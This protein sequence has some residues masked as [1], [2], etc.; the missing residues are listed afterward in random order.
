[1]H[2]DGYISIIHNVFMLSDK[3]PMIALMQLFLNG[4]NAI[5][6]FEV[7]YPRASA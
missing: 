1:M 6:M 5:Y 7:K 2:K 3:T 4:T